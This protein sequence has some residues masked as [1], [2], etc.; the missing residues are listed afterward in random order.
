MLGCRVKSW[1][2][3]KACAQEKLRQ[4]QRPVGQCH[5]CLCQS[6]LGAMGRYSANSSPPWRR[7]SFCSLHCVLECLLQQGYFSFST[8]AGSLAGLQT[9]AG[10]SRSWQGCWSCPSVLYKSSRESMLLVWEIISFFLLPLSVQE[11]PPAADCSLWISAV[12]ALFLLF[13]A[14]VSFASH[15]L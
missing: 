8:S 9:Y 1:Q 11:R 5:T 12:T 3:E 14:S 7:H 2:R 13:P 10:C 6:V 4:P 15:V